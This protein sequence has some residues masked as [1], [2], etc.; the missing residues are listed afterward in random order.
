MT[1]FQRTV[2][3]SFRQI[4]GVINLIAAEGTEGAN[5]AFTV[6]S[7]NSNGRL[8]LAFP[9]QPLNSFFSLDA[10][11]SNA[12]AD[13]GLHPAYE[14]SFQLR[15]SNA[16][17]ALE[18]ENPRDPS[19]QGRR[20]RTSYQTLKNGVL[21]GLVQWDDEVGKRSWIHLQSS[22]AP[23]TLTLKDF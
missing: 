18:D 21:N 16:R 8:D 1:Q 12:R 22:N 13:V 20:R 2:F 3:L 9:T 15:T 23:V 10:K 4:S 19:G 6:Q 5:S 17:P 14:G 11:T 7:I